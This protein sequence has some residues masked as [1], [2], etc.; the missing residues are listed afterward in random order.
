VSLK[1]GLRG[2]ARCIDAPAALRD[3]P[4][5]GPIAKR[6]RGTGTGSL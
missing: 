2:V 3:N 6:V 4:V 1:G 5:I